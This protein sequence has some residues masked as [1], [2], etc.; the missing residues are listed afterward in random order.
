MVRSF[1]THTYTRTACT[2][3]GKSSATLDTRG[4]QEDEKREREA[5]TERERER[6]RGKEGHAWETR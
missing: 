2:A 5:E 6:E 4:I 3:A 1:K